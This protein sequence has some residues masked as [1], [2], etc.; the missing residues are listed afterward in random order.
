MLRGDE[1]DLKLGASLISS[2]GFGAGE[3]L[4]FFLTTCLALSEVMGFM[5][6][7][8]QLSVMQ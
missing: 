2:L 1:Y 7:N 8:G 5:V 6:I 3:G 4:S